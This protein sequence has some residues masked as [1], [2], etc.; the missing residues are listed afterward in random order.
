MTEPT[1][2]LDE[3]LARLAARKAGAPRVPS[4]P[5]STD[6]GVPG[7]PR[8]RRKHPAAAGRILSLGLSASA[9]LAIIGA[10][11][12][13]TSAPH[14]PVAAAAPP[15]DNRRPVVITKV[16]VREVHHVEFVD[17]YGRPVP[18][19]LLA[20]SAAAGTTTASPGAAAAPSAR[21]GTA[22][23]SGGSTYIPTAGAP[24]PSPQAPV[25]APVAP[26]LPPATV[27]QSPPPSPTPVTNPPV[28][29]PPTVVTTPPP[30]P[31]PACSGTKCP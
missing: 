30:P 19:A 16:I 25:P 1:P 2:D 5:A 23:S 13:H 4:E 7:P 8:Q 26:G 18:S 27:H 11:G 9:F 21:S 15:V 17:Q 22:P 29:A 12:T 28:T 6:A 31:P 3:R 14:K 10:M 24:A 20:K